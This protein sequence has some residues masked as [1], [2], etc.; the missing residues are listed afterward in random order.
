MWS[1]RIGGSK[2]DAGW[3]NYS[4]G[5]RGAG[6]RFGINTPSASTK[7]AQ[8]RRCF[9]EARE[10]VLRGSVQ[11]RAVLSWLAVTTRVPSGL[12]AAE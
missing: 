4:R 7:T 8:G 9:H 10:R 12:N 6:A 2:D 3:K 1:L 5:Q 11:M